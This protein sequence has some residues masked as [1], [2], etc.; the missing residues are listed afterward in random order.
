MR[1]EFEAVEKSPAGLVGND[2]QSK[3]RTR[4]MTDI[5]Y[6]LIALLLTAIPAWALISGKA[7]GVW[8][9]RTTVSR[10]D[11]P[12]AYWLSVAAQALILVLFLLTARSWHLR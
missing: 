1:I 9:W 10:T 11:Q 2:L 4:F 8:W 3:M 7:L 12:T 5:N 6:Y